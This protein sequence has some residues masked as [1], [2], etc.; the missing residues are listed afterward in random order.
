MADDFSRY[1]F[2]KRNA[3]GLETKQNRVWESFRWDPLYF[4]WSYKVT[5]DLKK[6][7]E[8]DHF[9][10]KNSPFLDITNDIP[11]VS[12]TEIRN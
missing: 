9:E 6:V 10:K 12:A 2:S 1:F 3:K 7:E 5:E 11:F 4:R 8:L